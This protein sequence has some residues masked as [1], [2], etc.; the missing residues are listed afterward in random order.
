MGPQVTGG[1]E[2]K[3]QPLQAGLWIE[4][5]IL[6]LHRQGAWR[7]IAPG[8]PPVDQ[9]GFWDGEGDLD[10]G[11]PSLERREELLKE[12]DVGRVGRRGHGNSKIV[13]LGDNK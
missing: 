5:L 1:G 4:K 10:W 3:D 11:A 7:F 8:S 12:A 6:K 2:D 9:F 13:D